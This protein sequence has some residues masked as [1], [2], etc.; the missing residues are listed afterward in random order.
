MNAFGAGTF[1]VL[2]TSPQI[3]L[4]FSYTPATRVLTL[5]TVST[6]LSECF[7]DITG[8]ALPAGIEMHRFLC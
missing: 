6:C 2:P 5:P 1:S 4:L 8:T 7:L 3:S